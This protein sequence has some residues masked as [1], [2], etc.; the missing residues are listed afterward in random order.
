MAILQNMEFIQLSYGAVLLSFLGA[1]HWGLEIAQFGG[2]QGLKRYA[3]GMA[4][5]LIAWPSLLIPAQVGLATQWLGFTGLWIADMK[6]TGLGWS[7]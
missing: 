5:V 7:K 2:S 3:L 4:P 6:V 1:I